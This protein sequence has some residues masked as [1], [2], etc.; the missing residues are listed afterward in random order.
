VTILKS[1]TPELICHMR[2]VTKL[3]GG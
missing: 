2:E 1:L 3:V